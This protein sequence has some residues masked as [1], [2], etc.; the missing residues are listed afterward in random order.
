MFVS[1]DN[2][3]PISSTP[4]QKMVGENGGLMSKNTNQS[5][6]R[7]HVAW[8]DLGT[9]RPSAEFHSFSIIRLSQLS[10]AIYQALYTCASLLGVTVTVDNIM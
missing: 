5:L 3:W 10:R 4:L 1:I 6:Y 7:Q 8:W 2:A 9:S